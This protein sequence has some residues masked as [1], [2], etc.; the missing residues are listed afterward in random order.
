MPGSSIRRGIERMVGGL[1]EGKAA[2]KHGE[3][4]T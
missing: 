2:R 3:V 4:L 1:L